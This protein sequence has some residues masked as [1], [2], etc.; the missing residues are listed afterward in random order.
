MLQKEFEERIGRSVTQEEYVEAN[1]MYMAAGEMDKDEF[2]R[3]WMQ[4]GQSRL[5]QCLYNTAYNLNKALQEQKL[6]TNECREMLS[7]A[8]DGMLEICNGILDGKTV[9]HTTQELTKKAWWLVGQKEVTR[10][11]VKNGYT[12]DAKD[13]ET[14]INNLM[15]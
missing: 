15:K 3:E 2:S 8:A 6:M 11:K 4:F 13:R 10:R 5:V 12:L 7:D 14:I 1:A 9:E